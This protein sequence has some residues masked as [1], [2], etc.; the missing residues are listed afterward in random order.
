MGEGDSSGDEKAALDFFVGVDGAILETLVRILLEDRLVGRGI[1]TALLDGVHNGDELL[2]D[3]TAVVGMVGGLG[4]THVSI[5]NESGEVDRLTQMP[6]WSI[7]M[8]RQ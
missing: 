6:L 8:A 4:E 1:L 5:V 7:I 3:I 2:V